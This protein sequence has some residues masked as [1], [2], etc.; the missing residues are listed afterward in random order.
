[1]KNKIIYFPDIPFLNKY[2]RNYGSAW[3]DMVYDVNTVISRPQD[4]I[5]LDLDRSSETRYEA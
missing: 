3:R 5:R 1:M 2:I 4:E